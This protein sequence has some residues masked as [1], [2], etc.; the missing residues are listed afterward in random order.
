[1]T[2]FRVTILTENFD[3]FNGKSIFNNQSTIRPETRQN[4]RNPVPSIETK[5]AGLD[6]N[7]DHILQLLT[8]MNERQGN[9]P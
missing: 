4:N 5:I 8:Q 2:I 6:R 9:K 1:M 7:I 3:N